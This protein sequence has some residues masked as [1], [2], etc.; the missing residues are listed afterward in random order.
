[1]EL[2]KIAVCDDEE[3]ALTIVKSAV[4]STFARE[5]VSVELTACASTAELRRW[6][7]VI[8][9]DLLMLDIDMPQMSGIAFGHELR[10]RGERTDI[11]YISSQEDKVF[12]SL[13]VQP[14]TF[15]RKNRFLEDLPEAIRLFLRQRAQQ[16]APDR[17]V[18][19]QRDKVL[20]V[21]L[22]SI[23]YLEGARNCQ[24]I[25]IAGEQEP[26]AL[27][28]PMQEL[29]NELGSKGFIR[30]HKGFLVNCEYI[31]L[32][33]DNQVCLTNGISLP[34]SRRK[35]QETRQIFLAYMRSHG[36]LG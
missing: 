3:T 7:K 34:L 28:R 17:M 2:L 6:M 21:D 11:I 12:D 13:K 27:R 24:M 15:V 30:I 23:I 20:T 32:I 26:V 35:V 4:E 8:P 9:F 10:D 18:L 31:Q 22:K 5:R 33:Q 19:E 16:N 14:L 36:A 25:H 29:E 1:M